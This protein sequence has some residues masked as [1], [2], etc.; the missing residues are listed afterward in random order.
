MTKQ[1][2]LSATNAQQH[3]GP[4][5]GGTSPKKQFKEK[6]RPL[7]M[8]GLPALFAALGCNYYLANEPFVSTD[9]AYARVAK[10]SINARISGQVVEIAVEDN[11]SV[12]NGQVLFLI[13]PAPLQ[14]AAPYPAAAAGRIA[15]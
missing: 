15:A 11:Q 9:N 8:A 14:I 7:L 4:D 13:D 5:L 12:H 3:P 10:A 2:D 6:L 1:F